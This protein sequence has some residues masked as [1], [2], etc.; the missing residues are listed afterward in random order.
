MS[1]GRPSACLRLNSG[2]ISHYVDH[3]TWPR[4]QCGSAEMPETIEV[5]RPGGMQ[6]IETKSL[7]MRGAAKA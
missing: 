2:E 5:V 3:D 7:L 6:R 4:C 1:H